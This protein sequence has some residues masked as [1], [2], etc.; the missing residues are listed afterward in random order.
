[1]DI[2][3]YRPGGNNR[4]DDLGDENRPQCAPEER[5]DVTAKE[6]PTLAMKPTLQLITTLITLVSSLFA[7]EGEPVSVPPAINHDVWDELLAKY[8]DDHGLVAYADWK[9]NQADLKPPR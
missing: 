7:F 5:G 2:S 6:K 3:R 4:G 8:V 9:A 1:M